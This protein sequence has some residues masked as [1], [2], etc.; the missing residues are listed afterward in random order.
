MGSLRTLLSILDIHGWVWGWRD[1][2]NLGNEDIV[3]CVDSLISERTFCGMVMNR[4]KDVMK[5]DIQ[6]HFNPPLNVNTTTSTLIQC[7]KIIN[8]IQ[9][10]SG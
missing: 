7:D 4:P 1:G 6:E 10:G 8:P 2:N 9:L 5:L 3:E